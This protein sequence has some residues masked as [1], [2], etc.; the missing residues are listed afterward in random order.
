MPKNKSR[1]FDLV[2]TL[3][4][5]R[6]EHVFAGIPRVRLTRQSNYTADHLAI[7]MLTCTSILWKSN[8]AFHGDSSPP[9]AIKEVILID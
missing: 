9:L 7:A 4:Y 5:L 2:K 6:Y 1:L 3:M 8:G